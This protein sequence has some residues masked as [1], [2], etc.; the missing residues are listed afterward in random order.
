MKLSPEVNLI[1]VAHYLQALECQRDANR[2]VA[3][4][5][6]RPP[7]FRIWRWWGGQPHQSGCA[8]RA[9]PRAAALCEELYRSARRVLSS[10]STRLMPPS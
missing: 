7:T 9:Q 4:L 1:A 6:G 8:E 5:G 2:I 10:R 3:I